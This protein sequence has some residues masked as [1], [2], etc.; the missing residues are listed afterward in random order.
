MHQTNFGNT[1][2]LADV[3]KTSVVPD[4]VKMTEKFPKYIYF[5]IISKG[6]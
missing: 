5:Q 4:V 6:F 1:N 3:G 2:Q